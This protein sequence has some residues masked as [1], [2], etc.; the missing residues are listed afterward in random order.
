MSSI[1]LK[2]GK[3]KYLKSLQ[4]GELYLNTIDFFKGTDSIGRLDSHEGITHIYGKKD[5]GSIK[6]ITPDEKEFVFKDGI[7]SV[8]IYDPKEDEYK[9]THIACFSLVNINLSKDG[10]YKLI[11]EKMQQFGESLLILNNIE[12]FIERLKKALQKN[13]NITNLV[14]K[15]VVYIDENYNGKV[16]IFKKRFQF[17]Y[18]QEWRCAIRNY[19]QDNKPFILNIGDITDISFLINVQNLDFKYKIE[20]IK[21]AELKA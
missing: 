19:E 14:G 8:Q 4:Q 11:D 12:E 5:I 9:V 20:T 18:Q 15:P 21:D 3:E 17:A 16:D 7:E 10:T 2:F 1:L 6:I 13:T